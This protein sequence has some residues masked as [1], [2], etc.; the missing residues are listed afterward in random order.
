MGDRFGATDVYYPPDGGA[1]A[2]L[3]VST[4]P[5][6]AS[7][8]L[9]RTANLPIVADYLP[10]R[11]YQREL[12]A[13]EVV[14]E[15][16]E[17][18]DLLIVDGYVDLDPNG[19]AGLGRHVWDAGLAAAVVGV[20]KTAFRSATHAIPVTRGEATK[21]LYITA[22]GMPTPE[23]ADLIRNMAGTAR[24]PDALR[25]VDRISRGKETASV[26][27]GGDHR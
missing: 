22:A 20:A 1:T 13:I 9:R 8:T 7:I 10:G 12:P 14:L 24:L 27:P 26:D 23:A 21:P 16:I 17:P 4:E 25:L 6:F 2:A 19:R 5:N 3:I 11:F 18:L 15:N